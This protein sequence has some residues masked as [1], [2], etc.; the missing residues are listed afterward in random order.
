M[1]TFEGKKTQCKNLSQDTSSAAETF[2]AVN[3]NI[4][5]HILE[6][7][8]GSFFTEETI[9]D[10]TEDGVNS[11][12]T[13][14]RF[15]RLKKAYVTVS[16][17]RYVMEE[18]YDEDE[19]QVYQAAL[20]GTSESDVAQ[21]IIVRKD[22]Y[23]IYPTPSTSGNTITFRYEATSPDLQYDNY[24]TGT[25]TTLANGGTAV[26]ASGSTFTA[27]MAG[28]YFKTDDNVWYK[29]ATFLNTNTFTPY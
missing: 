10:F 12:P 15:I 21:K 24:T 19:W 23:E 2:F 3:I 16:S 13:P 22:R 25:I 6:T 8:L 7:E 9:T 1:I 18:V 14:A 27:A 28:R 5:Q 17:V 26:T 29:I 11:Y 4:G 20:S